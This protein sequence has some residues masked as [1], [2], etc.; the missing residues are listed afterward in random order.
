MIEKVIN[1][2]SV[3]DGFWMDFRGI[4]DGLWHHFSSSIS[5]GFRSA[6]RK[7]FWTDF[8]SKNFQNRVSQLSRERLVSDPGAILGLRGPQDL[9]KSPQDRFLIDF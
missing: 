9:P 3:F 5:D 6:I 7:V 2:G 8:G 1:F 4:L